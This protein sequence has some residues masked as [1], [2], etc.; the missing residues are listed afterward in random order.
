L[1]AT[2][3]TIGIAFWIALMAYAVAAG[4]AILKTP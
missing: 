2:P 3:A 1:L 4:G